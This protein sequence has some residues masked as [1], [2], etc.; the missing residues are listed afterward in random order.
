MNKNDKLEKYYN[1]G[2]GSVEAISSINDVRNLE[3]SNIEEHKVCY[4]IFH[5]QLTECGLEIIEDIPVWQPS[6]L[7]KDNSG[8]HVFLIKKV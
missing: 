2:F 3:L 4:S 7:K 8:S 1:N 6:E 5:N